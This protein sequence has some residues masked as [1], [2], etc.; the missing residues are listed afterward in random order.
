MVFEELVTK[1]SP[2]LRAIAKKL[3]DHYSAFNDDDLYQETVLDLWLKYRAGVLGNKTDSYILQGCFFF[4]KNYIRKN[5]KA[6]DAR[7]VSL[8]NPINGQNQTL[9]DILCAQY[10]YGLADIEAKILLEN[11]SRRLCERERDILNLSIADTTTR[12]IG[13]KLGISH[14][15][16]VKI[17]NKLKNKYKG[18]RKEIL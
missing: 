11:I 16:V 10:G 2:K 4:L 1:L 3:D 7:S 6:V 17:K 8:C 9:E 18:L 5:Y 15:M 12:D 14:V 13:K